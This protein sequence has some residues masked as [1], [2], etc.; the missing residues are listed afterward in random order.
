MYNLA[1]LT[2]Y[3][4]S[5]H[6]MQCLPS[7]SSLN[8]RSLYGLRVGGDGLNFGC[9]SFFVFLLSIVTEFCVLLLLPIVDID[10]SA[11]EHKT[12]PIAMQM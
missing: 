4:Y 11:R 1:I 10:S 8:S 5:V 3:I 7:F 12:R 9:L 6:D 2:I